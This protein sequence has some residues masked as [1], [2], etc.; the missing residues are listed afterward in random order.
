MN[1]KVK[2]RKEKILGDP[3]RVIAQLHLPGNPER[4]TKTLRRIIDLPAVPFINMCAAQGLEVADIFRSREG[5]QQQRPPL[6]GFS[7]AE[8][9]YAWGGCGERFHVIDDL[10]V[11]QVPFADLDA[12]HIRRRRYAGV[13]GHAVRQVVGQLGRTGGCQCQGEE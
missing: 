11:P 6:V 1:P 12:Q 3:K 8:P 9:L 2:R 5:Q 10:V 13:V 4:I 7:H